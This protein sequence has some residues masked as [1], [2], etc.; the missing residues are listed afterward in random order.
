MWDQARGGAREEARKAGGEMGRAVGDAKPSTPSVLG[1]SQR[2][3]GRAAETLF[4][5]HPQNA[6]RQSAVKTRVVAPFRFSAAADSLRACGSWSACVAACVSMP[7]V[8][9][10]T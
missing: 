4:A 5:C 1:L 8:L 3:I 10:N 7:N 6:H 2:R 9:R